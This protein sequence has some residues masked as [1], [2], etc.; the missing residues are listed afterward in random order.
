MQRDV[1]GSV[2]SLRF[3]LLREGIE[4]Y[5]YLWLLRT[6]GDAHFADRVVSD[7]VVDVSAFSRNSAALFAARERMARRIE[8][9]AANPDPAGLF[10]DNESSSVGAVQALKSRGARHVKLVA[11]DASEQLVADLAA[12]WIDSL[13]VQNP[14]QMG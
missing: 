10:A 13:V 4:D 6:L 5:E 14:F 12:G 9:L 3:E 2:S 1:D 8:K 7:L 11:F